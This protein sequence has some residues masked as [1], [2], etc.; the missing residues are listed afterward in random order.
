MYILSLLSLF[1]LVALFFVASLFHGTFRQRRQMK[2]RLLA[3]NNSWFWKLHLL[4]FKDNTC[5]VFLFYLKASQYI[6]AIVYVLLYSALFFSFPQSLGYVEGSKII[7]GLFSLFLVYFSFSDLLPRIWSLYSPLS[8]LRV[9]FRPVVALLFWLSPILLSIYKLASWL[10]HGESFSAFSDPDLPL[11]SMLKDVKPDDQWSETDRRILQSVINFRGRIAREI[12]RP[13]VEL[14]CLPDDLTIEQAAQLLQKEGYSRIP[15]YKNT[16]DTIIG[17]LFFRDVLTKYISSIDSEDRESILSAPIKTLM[18]KVFY[19]PETKKI[20]SL[21]QEFRNRQT[22]IA[23]IVDEYG[24]TSGLV[25]IEDIFEEIVG[26]ISDE[27]DV[28]EVLFT[29]SQAGGWIVDAK[30]N[31]LD[32]E[33]ELGIY[34]PQEEDYDTLAGY[35]FYRVGS[36]PQSGLVLHTDRF[37]VEI[38]KSNDRMVEQVRITPISE[39]T[40][41]EPLS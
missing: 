10:S 4:L 31:L 40:T 25:T 23:V 12:M 2:E 24:G 19:C 30:M 29:P 13:R 18:K 14:F 34:I 3:P 5:E 8:L 1:A 28:E 36:I 27:Y 33:E 17:V 41:E 15:V 7:A 20:S 22:H 6:L 37:E 35:I 38:L 9:C 39:P 11:V 21:L 26:E 32:I 16:V